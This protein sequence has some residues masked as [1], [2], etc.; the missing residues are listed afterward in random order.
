MAEK[1]DAELRKRLEAAGGTEVPVIVTIKPGSDPSALERK[2]L[3]IHNYFEFIS[4]V[5]GDIGREKVDELA[6]LEEV[7]KV[8]LDSKVSIV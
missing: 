1:L 2:G 6:R 5:S 3:R 7:E 8:E 4:A